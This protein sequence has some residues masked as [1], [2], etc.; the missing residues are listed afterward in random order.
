MELERELIKHNLLNPQPIP[1]SASITEI[2]GLLIFAFMVMV[3]FNSQNRQQN[4]NSSFQN[5]QPIIQYFARQN[6]IESF[7]NKL[8]PY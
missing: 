7:A 2:L 8:I 4:N 6:Q 5:Q 3:Y 1:K